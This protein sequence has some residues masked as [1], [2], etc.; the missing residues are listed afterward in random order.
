MPRM[1][2]D[3]ERLVTLGVTTR[4]ELARVTRDR[5][6]KRRVIVRLRER[7]IGKARRCICS[8]PGSRSESKE[9]RKIGTFPSCSRHL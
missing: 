4:E 7:G 1:R 2:E 6:A 5:P 8:V 9:Y 3:D